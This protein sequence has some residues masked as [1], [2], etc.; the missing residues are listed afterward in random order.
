MQKHYYVY[1]MTNHTK[2]LYT[3]I[4]NNLARRVSEHRQG[5]GSIFTK[6]Y[7]ITQLVYYEVYE[8]IW[9]AIA[10]EKQIK[11]WRRA[12]KVTLIETTN[13]SWKDLSL[14]CNG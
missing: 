10:R 8:N 4:T 3:G 12:K 7:K 11:S 6:K 9:D 13:P 14:E 2:T 5:I 1:I